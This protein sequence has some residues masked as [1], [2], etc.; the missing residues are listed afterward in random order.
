[1]TVLLAI[2]F[3]L[4]HAVLILLMPTHA[5]AASYAFLVT[6]P[7]LAAASA[8]RRGLIAGLSPAHG[9][10][11]AALS[12]LLWTLGM[13]SSLRLDLFAGNSNEAPGET[14]LLYILYGVP[15]SYAVATVGAESS[16]RVQRGIDAILAISLGY[17][18]FALMFSWTTLHG[19]SSA[20]SA[21]MIT[22]MFDIENAFL[23]VAT[24][25]RLL[26]ADALKTR[27][28]FG[29]LTAFTMLY[30]LAA[31]YYNHHVAMDVAP[32]I[33]SLYDLIIDVPFLVFVILAWRAPPR[34]VQ[35]LNPSVALVRFVR[36][37]S[38]LLLALSVL[39]IALLLLRQR[40]SLGVAGVILAVIGYGLRSILSQVRQIEAQD[41]LRHDRTALTELAFRDDLTGVPNRR[42]FDAA[43]EREWRIAQRTQ[44]AIALLLIDVDMF[45]LFNDRYGHPAGDACLRE[46]ATV[47][48]QAVQRPADLLARYGGEE[49]ALILPDTPLAGAY[50]VAARLCA[51]VRHINLQHGDSPLGR[52]TVSIGVASIVPT[53]DTTPQKLVASADRALYEAKR[54]GRNRVELAV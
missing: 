8:L 24:A 38:P 30:A 42:A 52:V 3:I 29:V 1:M 15:I 23:V 37:G 40:F 19:A 39:A 47:L 43:M 11:L 26:A 6:A 32:N 5:M 10:S 33:G 53:I 16:S 50:E 54:N 51:S 20:R 9:W 35:G 28:L 4:L 21:E 12:L 25:I 45:K 2:G 22:Y 46:V 41:V 44:R 48:R 34:V 17:L 36:I 14:M 7:L 31:A 13:I 27:H 49:F 18:Y